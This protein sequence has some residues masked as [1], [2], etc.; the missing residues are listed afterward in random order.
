M[1]LETA[2]RFEQMAAE[3]EAG[4]AFERPALLF[5][6]SL[7]ERYAAIAAGLALA[8]R[9]LRRSGGLIFRQA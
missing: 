7:I 6:A 1:L 4:K 3:Q 9:A 2:V 5:V 8:G